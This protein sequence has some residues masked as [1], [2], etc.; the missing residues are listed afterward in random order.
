MGRTISLAAVAL[1]LA[2]CSERLPPLTQDG[3]TSPD[4]RV[5]AAGPRLDRGVP[6]PDQLPPPPDN[7]VMPMECTVGIR[8]DNCCTGAEPV[9]VAQI[10]ADP[11]LVPYLDGFDIPPECRE[12]WDPECEYID[13]A[14][15]P[16][17][18]RLTAYFN[19]A[20]EF[21]DECMAPD[22]CVVARNFFQCCS[23]PQA[24]PR[25][26]VDQE[27]CLILPPQSAVP[28]ECFNPDC[29]LVDCW[30]C[31]EIPSEVECVIGDALNRC[32]AAY[33]P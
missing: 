6:L 13:C 22:D 31:P 25:A 1:T 28:E 23:C 32:Q 12:L 30:P 11:C 18:S 5:D 15:G 19:G 27:P 14:F 8:V 26:L 20:C 16:P 29:A 24:Y 2:A 7:G 3:G 33:G 10:E 4:L 9:T 21:V 17:P